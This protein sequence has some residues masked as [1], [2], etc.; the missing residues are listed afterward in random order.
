MRHG[1][2]GA[3]GRDQ[4]IDQ[5]DLLS[6]LDGVLM[7]FQSS[8]AV[9]QLVFYGDCFTGELTLLTDQD[10]GLVQVVGNEWPA[11]IRQRPAGH[12]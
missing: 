9:L 4:V 11:S 6:G 12:W 7:N 8:G 1:Q 2:V 5:K 10:K 3:A